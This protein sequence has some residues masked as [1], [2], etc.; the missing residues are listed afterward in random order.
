V[1]ADPFS[2]ADRFAF[3]STGQMA[4]HHSSYEDN[5]F[6]HRFDYGRDAAG[7]LTNILSSTAGGASTVLTYDELNRLSKVYVQDGG[8]IEPAIVSYTYDNVGSLQTV[9]YAN[10][11][12]H[13]YTYNALNRLTNLTH[14]VTDPVSSLKSPVSSFSYTLDARGYRTQIV[15]ASGRESHYTY[16]T[17]GRL[18]REHIAGDPTVANGA[19]DYTYDKA[20]NRLSRTS[21]GFMPA[22][23]DFTYNENDWLDSDTYDANGNTLASLAPDPQASGLKSQASDVYDFRNRLIRR[24]YDSGLILDYTYNAR[25]TRIGKAKRIGGALVNRKLFVVDDQNLTGYVQTLEEWT[26]AG[27]DAVSLNKVYDYGLD[28]VSQ[29]RFEWDAQTSSLKPHTSYL[30]YDGHGSVRA[31]ADETG[32]ITDTY[33]YDAFGIQLSQTGSTDNAYRYCGEYY[34]SDLGLYYLRARH[35]NPETGR[36]HTMDTYEGRP[37]EP[38]S[39]HKYMYAHANP[40]MGI[41]P[42]GQFTMADVQAAITNLGILANAMLRSAGTWLYMRVGYSVAALTQFVYRV[43]AWMSTSTYTA[44]LSEAIIRYPKLAGRALHKHHVIPEYIVKHLQSVNCPVPSS[45][46][47]WTVKINPAYHQMITNAIR[48]QYPFGAANVFD[49]HAAGLFKL[50]STL[51]KVYWEYPLPRG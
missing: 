47:N 8:V 9:S 6:A 28:L 25:G 5:S 36:F 44:R 39:L 2:H 37:E 4:W 7:N 48:A 14:W 29:T 26:A 31:L 30:I 50:L 11:I 19:A 27:F 16:D 21:S 49:H 34:D 35:M 40:V 41:D 20:G 17:L 42:S 10:G 24:T 1:R 18:T 3:D 32:T 22:N 45:I 43:Q 46:A 23:Q 12:E 38:L 33:T 15:E 51:A 13:A